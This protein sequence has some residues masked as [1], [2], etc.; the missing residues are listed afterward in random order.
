MVSF[1]ENDWFGPVNA[2]TS[3]SMNWIMDPEQMPPLLRRVAMLSARAACILAP[4]LAFGVSGAGV[5]H[6]FFEVGNYPD[7]A[8]RKAV[9]ALFL[10]LFAPVSLVI[11]WMAHRQVKRLRSLI[12]A[13]QKSEK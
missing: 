7:P 5:A 13:S 6:L 10:C 12:S 4:L 1:V 8:S 2:Q 9:G 3:R 11:W